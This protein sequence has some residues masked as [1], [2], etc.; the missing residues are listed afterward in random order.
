M[1]QHQNGLTLK[2]LAK[3]IGVTTQTV[4][5]KLKNQGLL[6]TANHI[7]NKIVLT[8]DNCKKF[9][10]TSYPCLYN[11]FAKC[12]STVQA[13]DKEALTMYPIPKGKG[14][15]T[16][17]KQRSGNTYFYIRDLPLFYKENGE[18]FMY[19]SEGFTSKDLAE[20]K[21]LLIISERDAGKFKFDYLQQYSQMPSSKVDRKKAKKLQ[22]SYY[23]FC[24]DYYNHRCLEVGTKQLYVTIIEDR[25]KPY[26]GN[27][28]IGEL[29][30]GI[31]Q[32][33][34]DKYTTNIKK[35]F[36]V[37][38]ATLSK[39]Y[40]LDLIDEDFSK[41]LIKPDVK[42]V[43]QPKRPLT[44]D[45]VSRFLHYFKGH[46]LEH[47]MYL[48]FNTGL[49]SQE[50]L[51]LTWADIEFIDDARGYVHVRR[52]IGRT[53]SGYGVKATKTPSSVRKVPFNSKTLV[54]LLK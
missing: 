9:I 28:A 42:I 19:K 11:E 37:L 48:I 45:E 53:E 6:L 10:A 34:V 15:I 21:R 49:R 43:K 54:E 3:F 17:I 22:Q 4:R 39:L 1:Q 5:N 52:A 26:F 35:M 16:Q 38:N 36:T 44:T 2:E 32:A 50:L 18:V 20:A 23:D 13:S 31:L 29:T 7:G 33:F 30:K 12:H 8:F 24:V 27:M 40:S 25:I 51:A 46:W 41:R 47:A 14:R